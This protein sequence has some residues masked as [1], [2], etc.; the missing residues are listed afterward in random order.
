MARLFVS[1]RHL[2]E[3]VASGQVALDGSRLVWTDGATYD[4][5]P[6]VHFVALVGADADPSDVLGRVKTAAQL[7]ELRAEHYGDSV[8][9]GDVG[10]QVVEG[11]VGERA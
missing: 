7:E 2:D 9:L 10:Y 4:L 1:Y 11:F 6:A 5:T 3:L 8:L